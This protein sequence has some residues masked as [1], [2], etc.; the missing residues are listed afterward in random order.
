MSSCVGPLLIAMMARWVAWQTLILLSSTTAFAE[1]RA[2][3]TLP[4]SARK[5]WIAHVEFL[6]TNSRLVIGG[7]ALLL[8]RCT[9][10]IVR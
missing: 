1:A 7:R 4:R 9:D 8:R 5:S 2:H 3:P 10:M 6:S